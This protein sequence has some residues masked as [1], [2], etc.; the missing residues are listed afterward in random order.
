MIDDGVARVAIDAV[1]A[2]L[3][4]LRRLDSDIEYL[5]QA[6]PAIWPRRAPWL[7]PIVGRLRGDTY[8]WK[9]NTYHLPQHGFARDRGFRVAGT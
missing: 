9:G 8:T 6:E 5:W 7:F 3:Q 1:G 2:E 4:S